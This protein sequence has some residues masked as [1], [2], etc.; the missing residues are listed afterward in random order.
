[1]NF[2]STKCDIYFTVK[3]SAIYAHFKRNFLPNST[4]KYPTKIGLLAK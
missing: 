4:E 2:K 1:M 3:N